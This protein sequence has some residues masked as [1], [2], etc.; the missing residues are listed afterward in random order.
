MP[1]LKIAFSTCPNDTFIFDALV[2]G[3]IYTPGFKFHPVLAD[4]R[5]LNQMA[6]D[7]IPDIVK[8]S[9]AHIPAI[10]DEYI[11]LTSGGAL[12]FDCGPLLVATNAPSFLQVSDPHTAIPGRN[13]TA[14]FLLNRYFPYIQ[15]KS[16][17]LFSEI[18]DGVA[19]GPYHGGLIIHESR[20]S[21]QAKG[22]EQVEDLGTLWHQQTSLPIP[23][24]CIVARRSLP[25]EILA[26][27]N[28]LVRKSLRYAFENPDASAGFVRGNAF[29]LSPE[30][31][32]RHIGLYVN[33]YSLDLGISGK[34]AVTTLLEG[35]I[36]PDCPIFVDEP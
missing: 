16:E 26:E 33:E 18:E 2:N 9:Y 34:K 13:T 10:L 22:L 1:D 11:A 31:I 14:N 23:L 35:E 28:A 17:V 5:E 4:I 3:R 29:S 36:P 6:S 21:F 30:V 12:G 20:F 15:K 25:A 7:K 8:V 19:N 24:G 32:A 27:I